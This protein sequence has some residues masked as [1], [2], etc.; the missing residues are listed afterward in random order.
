MSADVGRHIHRHRQELLHVPLQH[1]PGERLLR[2]AAAEPAI[3]RGQD[4][5]P[6]HQEFLTNLP[7]NPGQT[8]FPRGWSSAR[9]TPIF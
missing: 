9:F 1:A 7:T 5:L 6:H 2:R 8:L 3:R 4:H